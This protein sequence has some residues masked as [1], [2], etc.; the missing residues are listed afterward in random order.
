MFTWDGS[1]LGEITDA[2]IVAAAFTS[3]TYWKLRI[4][5]SE[6]I[7]SVKM[8]QS[9]VELILDELKPIFSLAKIGTHSIRRGNQMYL[10]TRVPLT[11][12]GAILEEP[13]LVEIPTSEYTPQFE[14]RVRE[15]LCFRDLLCVY[16]NYEKSIIVRKDPDGLIYPIGMCETKMVFG[17]DQAFLTQKM[18][19]KWFKKVDPSTVVKTMINPKNDD[20][21]IVISQVRS[22]IE[23]TINRIDRSMIWCS[24]F[25]IDRL[26]QRLV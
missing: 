5:L 3:C 25:I 21:A 1:Y 20:I 18:M 24:A 15:I 9:T 26:M 4:G 22:R 8:I 2:N 13:S 17:K 6:A 16:P 11:E 7:C 10:L 19:Q 14:K 23:A 12:S